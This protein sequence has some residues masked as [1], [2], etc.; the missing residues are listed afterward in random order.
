MGT[1]LLINTGDSAMAPA[2][3]GI[4]PKRACTS[5]SEGLEAS[6]ADSIVYTGNLSIEVTSI[7]SMDGI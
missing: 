5:R 2:R 6:G 3:F 1:K 4:I 7:L